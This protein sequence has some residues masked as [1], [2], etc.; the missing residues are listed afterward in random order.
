MLLAKVRL[1]ILGDRPMNLREILL[2]QSYNTL[3]DDYSILRKQNIRTSPLV[4]V[5]HGYTGARAPGRNLRYF[6]HQSLQLGASLPILFQLQ[7]DTQ[8]L[9]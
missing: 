7:D 2:Q 5:Q 3:S 6:I 8:D 4:D 1:E 9:G